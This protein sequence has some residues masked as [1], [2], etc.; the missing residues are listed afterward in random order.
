[1]TK[2][3]VVGG[4]VNN[5]DI[6]DLEMSASTCAEKENFAGNVYGANG[7]LGPEQQPLVC[8]GDRFPTGFATKECTALVDGHWQP[9][10]FLS[11]RRASATI[12]PSP[13]PSS[14]F[15]AIAMGGTNN[16]NELDTIEILKQGIWY[17]STTIMPKPLAVHCMV[18]VNLTTVMVIGGLAKNHPFT[19]FYSSTYLFNTV[20]EQW[21]EGPYLQ[22]GRAALACGRIKTNKNQPFF[23]I[24]VAGGKYG[25]ESHLDSVEI[26]DEV[27]GNWRNGPPLPVQLSFGTIVEDPAGGA[28]MIGGGNEQVWSHDTLYRLAHAGPDANWVEL[29]QKLS[30][31]R[32]HHVSL[33]VP[34]EISDCQL[35]KSQS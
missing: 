29:P 27:S 17:N 4:R 3:L 18:Q 30:F 28:I 1:M 19:Q 25:S 16:V 24:I 21:A 23:S 12:I 6:I 26:L 9:Y 5:T 33:L 10:N 8:L 11:Q 34:D 2:I 13:F 20:T 7:I 35:E 31:S 32:G 22:R 14:E 15:S